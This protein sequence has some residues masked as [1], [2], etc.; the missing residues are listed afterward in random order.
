M[1]RGSNAEVQTQLVIAG[2]LGFGQLFQITDAKD[3]SD[4]VARMLV[5]LMRKL[6]CPCKSLAFRPIFHSP[7]LAPRFFYSRLPIPYSLFLLH[8]R[9]TPKLVTRTISG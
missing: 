6:N 4:E 9:P 5:S 3:L 1:A 8:L 2:E 7:L